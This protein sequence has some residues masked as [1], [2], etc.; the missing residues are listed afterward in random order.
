MSRISSA[1][2]VRSEQFVDAIATLSKKNPKVASFDVKSI[3]DES[4]V[5][6]AID[7]GLDKR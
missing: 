2:F 5:Q 7:R 1:P 3:L 4:F 6:S